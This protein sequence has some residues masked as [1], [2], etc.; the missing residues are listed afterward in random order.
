MHNA[1]SQQRSIR[2]AAPTCVPDDGVVHV[3]QLAKGPF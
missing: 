1:V 3:D 2:S